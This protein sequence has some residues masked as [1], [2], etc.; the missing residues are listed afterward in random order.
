MIDCF[1]QILKRKYA[2]KKN[3][4]RKIQGVHKR[5]LQFLKIRTPVITEDM[6]VKYA[7]VCIKYYNVFY[8]TI[9]CYCLD[10]LVRYFYL[11]PL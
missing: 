7:S 8:H 3:I 6:T 5:L 11:V 9:C 4:V 2:R 10:V 1:N